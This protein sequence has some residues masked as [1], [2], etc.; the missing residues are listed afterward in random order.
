MISVDVSALQLK[1]A[2]VLE[3][4][5]GLRKRPLLQYVL[6]KSHVNESTKNVP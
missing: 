3:S 4:E 5:S 2:T 6:L 1:A